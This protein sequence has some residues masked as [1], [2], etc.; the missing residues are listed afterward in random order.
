MFW[1]YMRQAWMYSRIGFVNKSN[2]LS[3]LKYDSDPYMILSIP[4]VAI[5]TQL[6]AKAKVWSRRLAILLPLSRRNTTM[7]KVF[8]N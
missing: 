6:S 1:L 8:S 5:K 7:D 4:I 3:A 2:V